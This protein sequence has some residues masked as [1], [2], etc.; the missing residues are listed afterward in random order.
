MCQYFRFYYFLP[1]IYYCLVRDADFVGVILRYHI[2]QLIA[3]EAPFEVVYK[4]KRRA[5]IGLSV[6][7]FK[8]EN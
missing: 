1:V 6:I 7:I 4:Q 3:V 5:C 2:C 8:H